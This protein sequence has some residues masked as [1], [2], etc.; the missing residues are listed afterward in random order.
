MFEKAPDVDCAFV[1][2][3]LQHAVE[4]DV[5]TRPPDSSTIQPKHMLPTN[6]HRR[7][8]EGA[9]LL[10]VDETSMKTSGVSDYFL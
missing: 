4:D 7:P 6:Y 2:D 1:F 10:I 5:R 3:L 8:I 9:V